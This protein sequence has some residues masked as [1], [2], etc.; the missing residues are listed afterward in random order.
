MGKDLDRN[1]LLSDL[2]KIPRAF[3]APIFFGRGKVFLKPIF[4]SLEM[5]DRC[6]FAC[7][8]CDIWKKKKNPNRLTLSQ[9]KKIVL[10]LK[11][12]LGFYQLNLTGG[13]P[14]MNEVIIPTIKFASQNGIFVHANTN[15]FLVDQKTAKSLIGSGIG[16]ISFSVDAL[17]PSIHDNIRGK[18]GACRKVMRAIDY[19]L[20]GRGKK[21]NPSVSLTTIIL[22][23]NLSQLSELVVFAKKKNL[24]AVYFQPL[25]HNFGADCYSRLWY[26]KSQ[27][28]PDNLQKAN[29]AIDSLIKMKKKGYPIGNALFELKEYKDYFNSPIDYGKSRSCYVGINSFNIGLDG[30]VRLCFDL[31]PIGNILK[32]LPEKIWDGKRAQKLRKKIAYCQ[33]GCKV[34][35]CN[36]SLSK[37]EASNFLLSFTLDKLK[38]GIKK[39]F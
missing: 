27:L 25:W 28:W 19:T 35:L 12:W 7:L 13:E 10:D 30:K 20:E 2:G 21:K 29:Q 16:S 1:R 6:C 38:R 8:Q 14:L 15:G 31:E 11:K 4:I 24:D 37:R 22:K 36:M 18:K 3:L 32:E 33:R 34:L 39:I 5:E 17:T 9:I 26:K 23:Q